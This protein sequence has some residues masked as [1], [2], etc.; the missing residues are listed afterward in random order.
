MGQQLAK[1]IPA[2]FVGGCSLIYNENNID[3]PEPDARAADAM[4]DANPVNLMITS[5]DSPTLLEGQGD[6]NSRPAVLVIRGSNIVNGATVSIM[7]TSGT[8][9]IE[10]VDEPPVIS[11]GSDL[12]A[13]KVIA[14]VDPALTS[15]VTLDLVVKVTQPNPM[16]G[17]VEGMSMWQLKGLD[18]LTGTTGTVATTT[19]STPAKEYSRVSVT[20]LAWTGTG[21]VIVRATS[22][23]SITNAINVSAPAN[24]ATPGPGGFAGG[25]QESDGTG[26]GHGKQ[27]VNGSKGGGGAGFATA[28]EDGGSNPGS[29]GPMIGDSLIT[30]YMSNA[31]SGGGG[32]NVF[33]GG[34][35]GTL[36]LSA[37][38]NVTVGGM[39]SSNGSV[40]GS[41][42]L[43]QAAGGGGSGGV[44]VLRSGATVM[45]NGIS[46]VGGVG[47]MAGVMLG[48]AGDGGDGRSGRVR[49]DAA[50]VSGNIGSAHAGVMFDGMVPVI[51][52]S[53]MPTFHVLGTIG[54]RFDL[55]R[56][57]TAFAPIGAKQTV[58]FG[59]ATALDV[60]P[61]LEA[62]FN[63]VC[64][65]PEDSGLGNPES[66]NCVD[67]AYL[68]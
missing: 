48:G 68:P 9:M 59:G 58:D 60:M 10:I 23:I 27:G 49:I 25:G 22:S 57:S 64:L 26:P 65:I 63:R 14:R 1:L 7:P 15:A 54:D 29:A 51:T 2:V 20:N 34:G 38:G 31:G 21:K 44:V 6:D 19:T 12:I 62:G 67:L 30:R 41:G 4:P 33:G 42:S 32:S 11:A 8:A 66:R 40:G 16:G 43:L 36:E 46:V 55:Q 45:V 18:E 37:G 13:V 3:R 5:V 39:I 56:A 52:R 50:T 53:T 47:G 24:S 61:A 28:A 35:G 17:T